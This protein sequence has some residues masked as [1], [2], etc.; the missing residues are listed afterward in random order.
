MK[1][2]VV[3]VLLMAA[4]TLP[5]GA[6]VIFNDFGPGYGFNT[7]TGYT[8]QG[9]DPGY[10]VQAMSFVAS[11]THAVTQIDA[12]LGYYRGT[13]AMTLTLNSD[14]SGT[15]GTALL[16]WS[17]TNLPAGGSSGIVTVTTS[18]NTILTDGVTYWLVATPGASDTLCAWD[19]NNTGVSGIMATQSSPG[20]SW[21]TTGSQPLGAFDVLYGTS[22]V[23]EPATALLALAAL[24]VCKWGCK[25]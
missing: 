12:A 23:P 10:T 9:S 15:P 5:L 18:S 16:S 1:N 13:N 8:E 17:L 25:P 24:A 11:G 19:Y 4:P 6:G 3:F 20:G 22:G 21:L 14:N 2:T 7:T